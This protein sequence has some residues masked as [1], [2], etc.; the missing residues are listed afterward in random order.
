MFSQKRILELFNNP[1]TMRVSSPSNDKYFG[2]SALVFLHSNFKSCEL[3]FLKFKEQSNNINSG[4][5]EK[6]K[7]NKI[8]VL[9]IIIKP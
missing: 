7:R 5:D 3:G 8:N 1:I 9:I 6:L 2:S 4:L